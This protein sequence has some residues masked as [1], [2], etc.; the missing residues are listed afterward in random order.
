M[1]IAWDV[2]ELD[3]VG[4]SGR[5][6]SQRVGDIDPQ[7]AVEGGRNLAGKQ[8]T[9]LAPVFDDGDHL[10]RRYFPQDHGSAFVPQ[11]LANHRVICLHGEIED[12]ATRIARHLSGPLVVGVQNGFTIAK[13]RLRYDG[14]DLREVGNGVDSVLAKMIAGDVGDHSD[15]AAVETEPAAEDSSA[16]GFEDGV[17]DGG[18]F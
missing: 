13:D 5:H 4:Q 2:F 10:A 7:A 17:I 11:V 1:R 18:V 16:C 6:C 9:R 12:F 8:E 3:I 15:I 14:L